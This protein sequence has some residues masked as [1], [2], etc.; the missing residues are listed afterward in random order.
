MTDRESTVILRSPDDWEHF[1]DEF[2]RRTLNVNLLDYVLESEELMPK[3]NKPNIGDYKKARQATR[4]VTARTPTPD[5]QSTL[6]DEATQGTAGES[7]ALS[8]LTESAQRTYHLAYTMFQDQ[9]KIYDQEQ[10]ALKEIREWVISAVAKDYADTCCRPREDLRTWY[11]NL[12]RLAGLDESLARSLV[13]SKYLAAVKPLK[14][15]PKN[16]DPWITDWEKAMEQAQRKE[17]LAERFF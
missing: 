9:R 15:L 5:T 1:Q 3:P 12:K 14:K 13:Q 8:S 11:T 17:L 2:D 4:G 16:L 6:G 10:K 7:L